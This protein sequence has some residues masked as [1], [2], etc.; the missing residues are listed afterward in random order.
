MDYDVVVVGSGVSGLLSALVLSNQ[1][2]RVVV[3]EREDFVGG[4]ARSYVV[5]GYRVDVGP[6][7]ITH[8]FDGPLTEL[9]NDYFKVK[10]EFIPYGKYYVRTKDKF[11]PFPWT[12]KDWIKFD[13]LPAGDRRKLMW[14]LF[15]HIIKSGSKI[16]YSVYDILKGHTFSDRTWKF[17]D[18]LC[19]FM[20][21]RSMNETPA[22][23]M[24]KGARYVQE[25]GGKKDFGALS[26]LKKIFTYEG[27][28]H[29]A[30]PK[31]G[32]GSIVECIIKSFPDGMADVRTGEGVSRIRVDDGRVVGVESD[33]KFY[34][35]DVVVF[36]GE[37]RSLVD[38]IPSGLPGEYASNL[39]RIRQSTAIT[40]WLGLKERMECFEYMGS[41]IWFEDGKPF[42]AMPTSN[43]NKGFAP[44]GHQL[45]AFT[46][47]AGEDSKKEE[48]KLLETIYGVY[49][50][51]EEKIDFKHVQ[52]NHPEKAAITVDAF[53]PK[54]ESP[55][56]GL[57]L[58]GTDTDTRSMGITRAAFSV[59]E[60]INAL[61]SNE[62]KTRT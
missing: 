62:G 49:S 30:Y 15:S 26:R 35:A 32:V 47:Y 52:V 36:S 59:K 39:S 14:T 28:H 50:G 13:V 31:G 55:I 7:A 5:D 1:G 10:P 17:V 11:T 54:P 18:A 8:V 53:F 29:Q 2:K 41:E 40:V 33:G 19:Y 34:N 24:L 25:H 48:K 60:M 22:W 58:A 57:Y 4:N 9:M 51:I 16:D 37:V 56:R 20:S 45:V 42:W 3:L 6:H 46:S 43:Y 12:V 27:T 61:N 21:G 23:R 38:L 44:D